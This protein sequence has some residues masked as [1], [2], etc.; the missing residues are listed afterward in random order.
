MTYVLSALSNVL[1]MGPE[2]H[3][4]LSRLLNLERARIGREQRVARAQDAAPPAR[5][6]EDEGQI[7]EERRA[8]RRL[9]RLRSGT[10][11]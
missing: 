7:G 8:R 5:R 6:D 2:L 3:M 10:G 1:A 11:A 4:D 9:A